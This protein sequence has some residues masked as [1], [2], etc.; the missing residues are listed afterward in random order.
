MIIPI[1]VIAPASDRGRKKCKMNCV[2]C[3]F[4]EGLLNTGRQLE[5]NCA[6]EEEGDPE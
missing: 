1:S 2:E 3:K 5:I 4:Y 6:L